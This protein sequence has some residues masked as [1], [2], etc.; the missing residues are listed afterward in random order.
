M[1][2]VK[3]VRGVFLLVRFCVVALVLWAAVLSGNARAQTS[4]F[5]L[6]GDLTG[7]VY[8]ASDYVFRGISFTDEEPVIQANIFYTHPSGFYVGLWGTNTDFGPASGAGEHLEFDPTGGFAGVGPFGIHYDFNY[9]Y[10]HYPGVEA[11]HNYD[12]HEFGLFLS[13]D[14]G[15]FNVATQTIYSPE[16]AGDRGPSEYLAVDIG[17]P[18]PGRRRSPGI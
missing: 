5:P 17:V 13:R 9:F 8:L 4:E 14:F 10:F 2:R 11:K 15:L 3:G 16:Y 1:I 18:V 7:A 6:P 12:M